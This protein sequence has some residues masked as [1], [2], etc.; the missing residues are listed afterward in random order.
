MTTPP[1]RRSQVALWTQIGD[2]VDELDKDEL[3]FLDEIIAVMLVDETTTFMEA[4]EFI[5]V[6]CR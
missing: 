2:M 3:A 5:R 1:L 4:V 6:H